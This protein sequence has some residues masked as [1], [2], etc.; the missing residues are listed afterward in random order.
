MK[1]INYINI[2]NKIILVFLSISIQTSN[3]ISQQNQLT[4]ITGKWK[5]EKMV[6]PNVLTIDLNDMKLSR[7]SMYYKI[8]KK[9]S[10]SSI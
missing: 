9:I 7:N 8:R 10:I 5:I 4:K 6:Y 3:A 1:K 2:S